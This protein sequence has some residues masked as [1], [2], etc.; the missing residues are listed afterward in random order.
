MSISRPDGVLKVESL[1]KEIADLKKRLDDTT[2]MWVGLDMKN[3]RL[4]LMY[5]MEQ[6]KALEAERKLQCAEERAND[7]QK[8][9]RDQR[10][11]LHQL[12]SDV[13]K[14]D[15]EAKGYQKKCKIYRQRIDRLVNYMPPDRLND[16]FNDLDQED[17]GSEYFA[18]R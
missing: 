6:R 8:I 3:D 15:S 11:E 10:M 14:L 9:C 5:S 18:G 1:C 17:T 7:L 4:A 2:K 13:S 12:K 16:V